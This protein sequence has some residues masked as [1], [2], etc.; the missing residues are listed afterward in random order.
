[1]DTAVCIRIHRTA[2]S[3]KGTGYFLTACI[4]KHMA[5]FLFFFAC[6]FFQIYWWISIFQWY[7]LLLCWE[8]NPTE[9][10]HLLPFADLIVQ[11]LSRNTGWKHLLKV[12]HYEINVTAYKL[13]CLN[14][15]M[16][17]SNC[18]G[19]HNG[20]ADTRLYNLEASYRKE[21]ELCIYPH[22]ALYTSAQ[23]C[24]YNYFL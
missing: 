13:L 2:S 4:I 15:P 12:Y 21:K 8:F 3:G 20:K 14:E 17:T 22:S 1:M 6:L 11:E 10:F 18:H 24:K 16:S 19:T 9:H 5:M 7:F 23:Y